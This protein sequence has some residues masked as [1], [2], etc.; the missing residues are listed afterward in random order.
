MTTEF[1]SYDELVELLKSKGIKPTKVSIGIWASQNGYLKIRKQKDKV[2][3][4]YYY[5]L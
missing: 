2:R 5:K 1:I 4:T 3:T